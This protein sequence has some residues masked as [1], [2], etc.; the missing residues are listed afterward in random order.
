MEMHRR[1]FIRGA[2]LLAGLAP[3][4]AASVAARV[5]TDLAADF[6]FD[7]DWEKLRGEFEQDYS[8]RNFA[9]FLLAS[10]P[11]LVEADIEY[12]RKQLNRN[13]PNHLEEV[14]RLELEARKWAARYFG[15]EPGHQ[16]ECLR[17][18]RH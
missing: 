14:Y 10:R 17:G 3:L 4:G 11:R 8:W 7:G 13:A 5:G 12:H 16:R 9:G 2:G 18:S 1:N 6:S 15:A